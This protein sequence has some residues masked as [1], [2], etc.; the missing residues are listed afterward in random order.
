MDNRLVVLVNRLVGTRRI[1]EEVGE[2]Q[3]R[4]CD[5]PRHDILD[6]KR[7]EY[8]RCS[9][10]SDC[11]GAAKSRRGSPGKN[12]GQRRRIFLGSEAERCRRGER[13]AG[14]YPQTPEVNNRGQQRERG[15]WRSLGAQS[16]QDAACHNVGFRKWMS[17]EHGSLSRPVIR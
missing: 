7:G 15:G 2:A 4:G 3:V 5:E 14:E 13:R 16:L 8:W 11:S 10:C 6:K 9:Y 1:T 12:S 17:D